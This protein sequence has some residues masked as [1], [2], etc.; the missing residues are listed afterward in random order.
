MN[1]LGTLLSV[2]AISVGAFDES[3]TDVTVDLITVSS[4]LMA[5]LSNFS[6]DPV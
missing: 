1:L 3:I 6:T 4:V 5:Q 2:C